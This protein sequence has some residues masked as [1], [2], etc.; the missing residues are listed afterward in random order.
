MSGIVESVNIA[1]TRGPATVIHRDPRDQKGPVS[2]LFRPTATLVMDRK[3]FVGFGDGSLLIREALSEADGRGNDRFWGYLTTEASFAYLIQELQLLALVN[4]GFGVNFRVQWQ[5]GAEETV[6]FTGGDLTDAGMSRSLALPGSALLTLSVVPPPV[7]FAGFHGLAWV[8]LLFVDLL[9]FLL[10]FHLLRR[11]QLLE[12][13]V[14]ARTQEIAAEKAALKNEIEARIKAESFLERS[15]GLLDSIFEHIPGM[16][17]LKRVSDMR[18]ARIN[19]S[20]ERILGRTRDLLTGRSNEEIYAPELADF[21]T[22]GDIRALAQ[23]G[24]VELPVKRVSMPAATPRWIGYSKTVLRDRDGA[25]QY[26]LEFGED[27]TER[28]DLDRRL[29]EQL[30]FLE[31]LI[32]AFPGPVFSKDVAGRYLAVNAPFE[33]FIGKPRSDLIGKTVFDI[34][35]EELARNYDAADRALLDAGGKQVYES[36]VKVADG[37]V[38]ETMFH[39]AVF[40]SSD[41][42]KAGIVGIALDISARKQAERRVANLNRVLMVLSEINHLIIHT[43]DRDRLLAEARRILQEKGGFPAVW[44][45]VRQDS[46]S[47]FIADA[48]IQQYAA[49]ICDEIENPERRCW[50][51]RRLHCKALDC[52]NR[53]L[54][55]E[56]NKLGLQSLMHLPLRSGDIEWGDIGILGAAGQS[57]S[58]EEQSLLEE[59]AGNLSFALDALSQE[60]RRRAAENKFELSARVFENN[61]EGIIITD[62]D[63]KIVMVNKAFT[64]VT[65]YEPDEVIGKTPALLNSGRHNAEFFQQMSLALEQRG[66]WC[67]E[68]I[69]RRK[70]GEEFPEWMTISLVRNDEGEVTNHVT[71][72]SDLTARRKIEARVEFLAHYDSLTALPNRE[73]FS[74]RLVEALADA[75]DQGKRVAVIYFDLDRF[76]LINE[77]VGHL[78]ADNLL[79]EVSNRL[80]LEA[81]SKLDVARLGGDQFAV[82][83]PNVDSVAQATQFVQR[84]QE[85]LGQPFLNF[86]EQ[87]I[88]ISASVGIS[89]FPEDGGDA[90]T[91]IRNADSAMYGAIEDGGNTYR[92]FR[93]E[94]NERAAERVQLESRLHHALERGELAVHF[95]PFISTSS[96]RIAGAEALL[97]WHCPELGGYVNPSIFIPLLEEIGLI[98]QVGEWVLHQ[99]CAEI[100]S[101]RPLCAEA[102]FVA[103][104]ISALQLNSDLP[105][106]VAK[107]IADHGISPHQLEIELTESAIMR[108]TD[109]GIR[110]LHELKALGVQLSID[111]FGTGYSSLS[112]LKRL[113]MSTLKI[114]RSFV[115]DTPDDAEAVSITRAILG[116]GHA[117]HLKI[118]A[119]GVETAGQA[120]FLCHNGC[121]LLQGYY[122]SRPINAVEFARLLAE[123]PTFKLPASSQRTLQL[124]RGN[125]LY[126]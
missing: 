103:V 83:I 16:I 53:D 112:Y 36:Q 115:M 75:T 72:F 114:D 29:M 107:A 95:Q 21:L 125:R 102:L 123:T 17:V 14:E 54:S 5:S 31:Q 117:L 40:H 35:P 15:H 104:N 111:D 12:H 10:T 66:E 101:W 99:A 97:R 59:L 49:R 86:L 67:G 52:C 121:D 46:R 4:D 3:P 100:R 74:N 7:S 110:M 44:I 57:F 22:Q 82:L 122:F 81:R 30:H 32:E 1:S 50:P 34:A 80:I 98:K 33:E 78:A 94:M 41:G 90:E 28:E 27:L 13:E 105:R 85:R 76:K 47:Q 126:G 106:Q 69:N 87:E 113:P 18:I 73:H 70:N 55:N 93:Q 71:V 84:L 6:I 77:T 124:L 119:E 62:N 64:T 91:L 92:F 63:N 58:E 26:I 68:I 56:L 65:G 120:E 23:P 42:S 9:L 38:T 51:K 118:I 96:G 43:R 20:A 79:I 24:L 2:I 116:L 19:R 37:S 108:D 61:S 39:K 25:P 89:V 48:S 11:P 45:H 88:H 8:G 60:E 109:H